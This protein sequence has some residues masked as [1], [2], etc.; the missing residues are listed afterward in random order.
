MGLSLLSLTLLVND[1]SSI[2]CLLCPEYPAR[3]GR[4]GEGRGGGGKEEQEKGTNLTM[5]SEVEPWEGI[6][7][8][9]GHQGRLN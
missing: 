4:E 1:S 5:V 6:C 2:A 8:R 3:N 9:Q 7:I